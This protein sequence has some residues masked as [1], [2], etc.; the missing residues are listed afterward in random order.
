MSMEKHV[1][2]KTLDTPLKILFWTVPEILMLM[3]PPFVGLM[4]NQL[5]LGI[6][7]S[8]MGVWISRKYQEHF[9]KGQWAAVRYWFLP[10]PGRFK[11]LPASSIREYLG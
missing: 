8:V 11:S 6:G 4:L 1:I 9:G 10:S 7:M 3:V 5:T 2:L